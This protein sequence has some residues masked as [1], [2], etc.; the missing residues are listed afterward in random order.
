MFTF[1]TCISLK[2][3]NKGVSI[4]HVLLNT[5]VMLSRIGLC[6]YYYE[7]YTAIVQF[8]NCGPPRAQASIN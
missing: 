2:K 5:V 3:K 7:K 6:T 1:I 8:K 4:H